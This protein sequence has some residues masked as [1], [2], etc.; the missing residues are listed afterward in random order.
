[1]LGTLKAGGAYVPLDPTYPLER[2]QYMMAHA[3]VRMLLTEQR[4]AGELA[5]TGVELVCMDTANLERESENNPELAIDSSN[6]AYV[7]YTSGSTGIPKGVMI[8]HAGLANFADCHR[9]C[10]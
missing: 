3:G 9:R 5:D 2:L 10:L 1:M 4:L 6:L 8:H 7:I